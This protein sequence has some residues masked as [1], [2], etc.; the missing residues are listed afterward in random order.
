MLQQ[1]TFQLN[2]EGAHIH[3]TKGVDKPNWY[4]IDAEGKTLGRLATLIAD[5]VY[6]KKS[7]KYSRHADAGDF[8]VV[9]NAKKIRLTGN[10]WDDKMYYSHSGWTGGFKIKTA[11]ELLEKKPEELLKKA[12]WGMGNKSSLARRQLKKLKVYTGP[13]HENAAQNP[14][15]LPE[16][17]KRNTI[18]QG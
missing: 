15:E 4:L 14:K 13:E 16:H 1:K 9:I 18:L 6:G 8:V 10:K 7:P 3:A 5:V 12:V 17:L 2:H 11:K